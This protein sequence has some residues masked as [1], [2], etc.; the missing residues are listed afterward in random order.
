MA[1]RET[2]RLADRAGLTGGL[3]GL[4]FNGCL[5]LAASRVEPGGCFAG[6]GS[7][8]VVDWTTWVMGVRL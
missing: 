5:G 4:K 8:L 2:V 3:T 6:G 1:C 7:L